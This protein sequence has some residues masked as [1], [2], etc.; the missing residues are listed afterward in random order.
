MFGE[1]LER[2]IQA[3]LV[4]VFVAGALAGVFLLK[5]VPWLWRLAKPYI[6]ALTG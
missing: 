4:M 1:A 3:Y 2:A 6:H 5:V